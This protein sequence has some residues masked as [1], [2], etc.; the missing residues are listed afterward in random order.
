MLMKSFFPI[1]FDGVGESLIFLHI[2][3]GVHRDLVNWAFGAR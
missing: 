3:V 2:D 1:G